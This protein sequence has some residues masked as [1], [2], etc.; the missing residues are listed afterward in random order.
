MSV[1][2][3]VTMCSV[4]FQALSRISAYRPSTYPFH[5]LW[6]GHHNVRMASIF[7]YKISRHTEP[8]AL[9]VNSI[10]IETRVMTRCEAQRTLFVGEHWLTLT[11]CRCAMHRVMKYHEASEAHGQTRLLDFCRNLAETSHGNTTSQK[12]SHSSKFANDLGN[13]PAL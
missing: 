13:R 8:S 7:S 1:I 10:H 3:G 5:Q 12:T 2:C 11:R 4:S 9:F 6:T